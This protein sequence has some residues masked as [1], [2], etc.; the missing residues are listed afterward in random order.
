MQHIATQMLMQNVRPFSPDDGKLDLMG[1]KIV[2]KAVETEVLVASR[3]RC[4][5]CFGLKSDLGEKRGQLA[6]LD[7]DRDNNTE[8]NLAY[9][10]LEHHDRYDSRTSQ[11]KNYTIGEVKRYRKELY[12][13][14]LKPIPFS[15][16]RKSPQKDPYADRIEQDG[17]DALVEVLSEKYYAG[18]NLAVL[19]R[20]VSLPTETV[21]KLLF[22]LAD[23]GLV[24]IDRRPGTTKRAFSLTSSLENRLI[25]AFIDSL[26]EKVVS[27]NRFNR[28]RQFEIDALIRTSSL[29]Y[30][31]ET[32]AC[33]GSLSTSSLKRRL[34][35]LQDA[36]QALRIEQAKDVLVIGIR[37][38]TTQDDLD[39][40]KIEEEGVL[41]RFVD[42]E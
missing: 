27:E 14:V 34:E 11:S 22:S 1:R 9:L 32:M 8:G 38:D 2:P 25:D 6:H 5:L 41:V 18:L 33:K 21:E 37:S 40:R 42:L 7:H 29:T 16:P 39:L 17:K 31:V 23:E 26:N 12:T 28:H 3:R 19:A 24:R 10:C 35:A 36:K 30:A 15:V 4:C 13:A 20:D